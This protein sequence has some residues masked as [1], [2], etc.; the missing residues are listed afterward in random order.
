MDFA[1]NVE[2]GTVHGFTLIRGGAPAVLGHDRGIT[3][4][5][6]TRE[7]RCGSDRAGLHLYWLRPGRWP[8]RVVPV[9]RG[10]HSG[11]AI[12]QRSA[13]SSPSPEGHSN[14]T[15]T[16]VSASVAS[17]DIDGPGRGDRTH[18]TS[19]HRPADRNGCWTGYLVALGT[20]FPSRA[21]RGAAWRRGRRVG[22]T[23]RGGHGGRDT[24]PRLV[25]GLPRGG[26]DL[27]VV[28][29]LVGD[30]RERGVRTQRRSGAPGFVL[31]TGLLG[32]PR[33][34]IAVT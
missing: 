11:G 12:E 7:Q 16:V 28:C 33:R 31:N 3:L 1:L 9:L 2:V 20:P 22:P 14:E 23:V 32:H 27:R 17:R 34:S 13:S 4:T 6:R 5:L 29:R 19:G 25:S 15:V 8:G 26:P 30:R 10:P 18:G 21:R 24:P